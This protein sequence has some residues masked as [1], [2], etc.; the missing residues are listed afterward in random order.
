MSN[1]TYA[2]LDPFLHLTLFRHELADEDKER[3]MN[4]LAAVQKQP[5]LPR[6]YKSRKAR[7]QGNYVVEIPLET[8]IVAVSY[9]VWP[10]ALEVR[11]AGV[12][13]V[14]DLKRAWE[15]TAGLFD[16]APRKDKD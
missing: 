11:I 6:G 8:R 9:E 2:V 1:P 4:A 13:D 7:G 10:I 5:R 15:W 3:V 12:R 14:S 16:I